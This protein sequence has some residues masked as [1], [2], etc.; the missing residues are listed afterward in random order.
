MAALAGLAWCLSL[1]QSAA[2]VNF[3]HVEDTNNGQF[4]GS[5]GSLLTGGGLTIGYF[6]GA[7]PGDMGNP[8]WVTL[9]LGPVAVVYEDLIN[10]A[11]PY[12][13]VDLRNISNATQA[14]GFDWNFPDPVG[15]TVLNIPFST[16]SATTQIYIFAFNSGTLANHFS[17][18]T[19]WAVAAA[20]DWLR[21][22]DDATKT[23]LL[24]SVDTASE[25]KIGTDT[26]S[27]IRLAQAAPEP[28]TMVLVLVGV[29]GLMTFQ[30]KSRQ[31][32]RFTPRG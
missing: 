1:Q 30:R 4:L 18:S 29:A 23:L 25:L 24:S 5:S 32:H 10:P 22:S 9:S 11:G 7:A 2:S 13:F 31:R 14:T 19:E 17:G 27:N 28:S 20:S 26:G 8:D 15:G 3:G 6:A 16:L 21:P 12:H